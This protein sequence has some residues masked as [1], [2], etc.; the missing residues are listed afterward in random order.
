MA[1]LDIKGVQKSFGATRVLHGIDFERYIAEANQEIAL[2]MQIVPGHTLKAALA[3]GPM[4]PD[5]AEAVLKDIARALAY[6]HRCG[7]VPTG[8]TPPRRMQPTTTNPRWA[9]IRSLIR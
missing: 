3:S 4:S 9:P 8:G 5:R 1:S 6:A 7:V 2:V